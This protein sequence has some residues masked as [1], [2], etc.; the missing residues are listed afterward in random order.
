M[1]SS[2]LCPMS[3]DPIPHATH[4][5]RHALPA[6]A[7]L[8]RVEGDEINGFRAAGGSHVCVRQHARR[9]PIISSATCAIHAPLPYS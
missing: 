4:A 5:L 6:I 8:G 1:F 2:A 3:A 7:I 9:R